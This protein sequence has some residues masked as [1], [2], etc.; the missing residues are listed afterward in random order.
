MQHQWQAA[1][2]LPVQR[3]RSPA[4]SPWA[5]WEPGPTSRLRSG[6]CASEEARF[7]TGQ[8]LGVNGGAVM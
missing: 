3:D 6:S 8:V 2:Y 4:T 5:T 1:G 7:I